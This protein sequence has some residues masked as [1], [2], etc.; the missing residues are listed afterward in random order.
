MQ[1]KHPAYWYEK[2]RKFHLIW[3]L[4]LGAFLVIT[5]AF[6]EGK[7]VVHQAGIALGEFDAQDLALQAARISLTREFIPVKIS[8][9]LAWLSPL[10]G[11]IMYSMLAKSELSSTEKTT[12]L[13]NS[14]IRALKIVTPI[15]YVAGLAVG[16]TSAYLMSQQTIINGLLNT[17]D[18]LVS[19]FKITSFFVV[20]SFLAYLEIKYFLKEN[21]VG[22]RTVVCIVTII[23]NTTAVLA[24]DYFI[25]S[26]LRLLNS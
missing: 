18:Y 5:Y 11:T 4:F 25:N 6:Q 12:I 20:L 26:V 17:K 2:S 19:I 16:L 23:V 9:T 14:R 24:A 22:R 7:N 10:L 13:I 3:F 21:G 8:L 15:L 1:D